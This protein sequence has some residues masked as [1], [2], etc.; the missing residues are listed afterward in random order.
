MSHTNTVSRGDHVKDEDDDYTTMF[1]D[2]VPIR[3]VPLDGQIHA[4]INRRWMT[5]S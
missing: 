4:T 1:V 5:S 3:S 2:V